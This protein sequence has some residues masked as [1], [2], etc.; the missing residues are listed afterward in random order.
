M[1]FDES[2]LPN[3]FCEGLEALRK[4]E[5]PQAKVI[6]QKGNF[7]Y[8][9]LGKTT[10]SD[11][12]KQDKVSF[13]VRVPITFPNA[14]PYGIVTDNFL[15]RN[16]GKAIERYHKNHQNARPVLDFTDSKTTGFFSWNWKNMP[17][18]SPKDMTL[19]Y[20]WALKRIREA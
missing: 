11:L 20:Q 10:L 13:F 15:V 4:K 5:C 12:Y 2:T 3:N 19:V 7:V 17:S 14:H 9:S 18:N 1:S 16:D 6:K 8:I